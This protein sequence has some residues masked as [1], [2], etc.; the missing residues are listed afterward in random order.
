MIA[1]RWSAT[2]VLKTSPVLIASET[3]TPE[4][5]PIH[6][7]IAPSI[8]CSHFPAHGLKFR[9]PVRRITE[10][11]APLAPAVADRINQKS[12]G[13][14]SAV[15]PALKSQTSTLV[16]MNGKVTV[17]LAIKYQRRDHS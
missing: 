10:K 4:S 5:A 1:L 12:V 2:I 9:V 16:N 3:T 11:S 6:I 13:P 8:L 7:L 15:R 14:K 17:K